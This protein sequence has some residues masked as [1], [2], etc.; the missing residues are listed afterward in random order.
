MFELI[1]RAE[2]AAA[3]KLRGYKGACE[4]LHG[5]NWKLDVVFHAP[6]LNELGMV[7]D[8]RDVKAALAEV[9]D[10]L[11]HQFLN[12]TEPFKTKNP[13]TENIARFVCERLSEKLPEGVAVRSVTSWESDRCAA[14]YVP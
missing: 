9:L 14:T 7:A 5:H 13:T 4:N 8:F 10:G 1:V 3:H 6:S 11:D 12:E 2:F